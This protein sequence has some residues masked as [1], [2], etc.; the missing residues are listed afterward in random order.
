MSFHLQKEPG[1]SP[2]LGCQDAD[3]LGGHVA[4]VVPRNQ[5]RS[6][7]RPKEELSLLLGRGKNDKIY[8]E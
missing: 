5:W 4:Q 8:A 3:G 7:Y 1:A 6:H 2:L